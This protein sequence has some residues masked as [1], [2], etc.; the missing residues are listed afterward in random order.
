MVI[1]VLAVSVGRTGTVLAALAF[2]LQDRL[3]LFA[4]VAQI[5][6][7]DREDDGIERSVRVK[8]IR[9]GHVLDPAFREIRLGVV[10][11]L[12]H[13]A[14]EAGEILGDDHVRIPAF[15]VANHCLEA[16]TL[17]IRAAPAVVDVL[18]QDRDALV[19]TV[20]LDDVALVRD[21]RGLTLVRVLRG[22]SDI[23]ISLLL[24]VGSQ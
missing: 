12:R 17:E 4:A 14:P 1:R 13:V 3:D 19:L 23:G 18:V 16:G 20:A 8:G 10:A 2:V 5:D 24:L 11:G 9:Y 22:E 15:Q 7:V 21:T 6:L